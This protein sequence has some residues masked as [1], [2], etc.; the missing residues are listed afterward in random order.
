MNACLVCQLFGAGVLATPAASDY[1]AILRNNLL[2]GPPEYAALSNVP[3]FQG[4]WFIKGP[5]EC[6]AQSNVP[7]FQG[8]G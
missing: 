3:I 7:I 1:I 5:P 4:E 2:G 8:D 6:A